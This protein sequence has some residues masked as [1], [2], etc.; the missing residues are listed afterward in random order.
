MRR[1][2]EPEPAELA[3]WLERLAAAR[4]GRRRGIGWWNSFY[5]EL[6]ALFE[7][8]PS[9]LEGR[10]LLLDEEWKVHTVATPPDSK[11]AG[12]ATVFFP[13]VR[14][15]TEGIVDID[16][17]EELRIPKSLRR[18]IV[19]MHPGLEWR[20]RSGRTYRLTRARRFLEDAGLVKPYAARYLL[21]LLRDILKR[22]RSRDVYRDA[23][24]LAFRLHAARDYDQRPALRELRLR[25]PVRGE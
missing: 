19:L 10:R 20:Q 5:D 11:A 25:V 2:I 8:D 18:R 15:R 9:P 17:T 12:A 1:G 21:E 7:K 22:S 24:R 23:L 3:G 14:G 4:A 13:P 6:A 16:D